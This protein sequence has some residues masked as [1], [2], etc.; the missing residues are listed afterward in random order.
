MGDGVA[1]VRTIVEG[2]SDSVT[3]SVDN[4]VFITVSV[5]VTAS[6]TVVVSSPELPPSTATTEYGAGFLRSIARGR[7]WVQTSN[8]EREMLA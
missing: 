6:V 3:T 8:D 7:A 1:T 5:L 2:C 4:W